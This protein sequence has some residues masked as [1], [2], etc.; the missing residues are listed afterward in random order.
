MLRKLRNKIIVINVALVSIVLFI[1]FSIF[2]INAYQ[3]EK[4]KLMNGL[5]QNAQQSASS[6]PPSKPNI[7][8]PNG[9]YEPFAIPSS[10]SVVI[11]LD[12]NITKTIENNASIEMGMLETVSAYAIVQTK[13]SGMIP[14]QD[15]MYYKITYNDRYVISF[16]STLA[17]NNSLQ[18]NVIVSITLYIIFLIILIA[19]SAWL[20]GFAVRPIEKAW[21]QQRQFVA[22]A[23]HELKTPLTVLL[24]NNNILRSHPNDTIAAQA[25]WLDS[26]QEVA[27]G[28][29]TLLDQML[30]QAKTDLE[31]SKPQRSSIVLVDVVEEL[32]L[33]FE[34][35]AYEK[36]IQI[37]TNI[38][39]FLKVMSH[40]AQLLQL[41]QILMDNA[42]KYSYEHTTIELVWQNKGNVRQLTMINHGDVIPTEDLPHLFDRFYRVNKARHD[43]G[44]GLGLAIAK[45]IASSLHITLQ[46]ESDATNGT[47]FHLRFPK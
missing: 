45:N 36:S 28:M 26:N 4:N 19:I 5:K 17:L 32:L 14:N 34:P 23:S 6:I 46:V 18:S 44:Y 7:G 9:K 10:V 40:Y 27:L 16:A 41:L 13:N 29:K 15:L 2:C 3:V 47:R 24:A 43:D 37:Q 20:A 42:V 35:I 39:D 25:Q 11:D 38:P 21:K 12:G 1:V 22:D 30:V 33:R 8:V 31:P